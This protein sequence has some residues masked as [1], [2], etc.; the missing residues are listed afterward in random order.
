MMYMAQFLLVIS[1][2]IININYNLSLNCYSCLLCPDPFDPSSRLVH[3]D[4]NCQ[5]CAKL[6]VPHYFNP[7]R[8]CTPKCDF[9][10][11][12]E[13]YPK[14]TYHCCQNNYCNKSIKKNP[15]I[16]HHILLITIIIIYLFHYL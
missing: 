15:I 13:T 10:Y 1:L 9:E 6:E 5:W 7:I 16:I 14:L 2:I 12:S 3:N 4:S 8:Q 11:F